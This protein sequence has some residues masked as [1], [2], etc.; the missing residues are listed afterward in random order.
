[1]PSSVIGNN[2]KALMDKRSMTVTSLSEKSG[3]STA[4]IDRIRN[5]RS[6]NTS[7]LTI[8][9]LCL[10]LDCEPVDLIGQDAA[11]HIASD[12]ETALMAQQEAYERQIIAQRE[13]HERQMASEKEHHTE[14]V[15]ELRAGRDRAKR[16]STIWMV[17]AIAA[18]VGFSVVS[19]SYYRFHWDVTHPHVGQIQYETLAEFKE[20]L[21]IEE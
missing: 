4:T 10:A 15:G 5:N 19:A 7:T 9:A 16:R 2:L 3:V 14:M 6:P 21:G 18:L 8:N 11:A 20:A 12:M 1:M 17:I 13:A